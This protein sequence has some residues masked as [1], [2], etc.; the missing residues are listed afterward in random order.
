MGIEEPTANRLQLDELP[1]AT[2][3]SPWGMSELKNAQL[4]DREGVLHGVGALARRHRRAV[5]PALW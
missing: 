3:E 2:F 5:P 4:L 1:W